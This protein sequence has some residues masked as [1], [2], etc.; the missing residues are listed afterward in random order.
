M[1][2][3][4]AIDNIAIA[5]ELFRSLQH[6]KTKKVGMAVKVDLENAYDWVE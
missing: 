3:R 4:Q 1:S 2:G 5:Q 6:S